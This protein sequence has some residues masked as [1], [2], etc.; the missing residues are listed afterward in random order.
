VSDDPKP[1]NAALTLRHWIDVV[2][3]NRS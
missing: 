3:E 2:E 1:A